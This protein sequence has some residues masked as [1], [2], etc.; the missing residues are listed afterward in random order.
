MGH[1]LN[2]LD[3][4]VQCTKNKKTWMSTL[5]NHEEEIFHG[6]SQSLFE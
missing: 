1:F 3:H 4:D 2:H 5:E 6:L